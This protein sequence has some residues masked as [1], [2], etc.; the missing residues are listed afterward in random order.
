MSHFLVLQTDF[1]LADGAVS[2]MYGV[3]YSVN[4]ELRVE[5]LT[6]EIPA[7]DIHAAAYRLYQSVAYWPKGTVF[8]SVVDPGVGGERKS[9]VCLTESGHYVITP[10]NG[11]LT[12]IAYYLGIKEVRQINETISRLAHSSDSHTFHG[13]DIYAYNGAR[14]ASGEINFEELGELIPNESVVKLPVNLA[15]KTPQSLKGTVDILDIRFGSLWTNIPNQY[16]KD[17]EIGYQDELQVSIF[18]RGA[19]V[20]QGVLPFVKSFAEVQLN[21]PLV[22]INSLLNVAVAINQ[23]SFADV[24]QIGTGNDWT[25]ELIK[26]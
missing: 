14:L 13:R 11:A 6:H 7:Y 24:F 25:I 2:A 9:V 15:S 20:Y 16:V 23:D 18:K 21:E 10:D 17:L 26:K 3:A 19:Q 4:A 12:Y 8:V 1:G 22:Y 5:D